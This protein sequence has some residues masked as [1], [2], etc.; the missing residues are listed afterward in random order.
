M[1]NDEKTGKD[2]TQ[3]TSAPGGKDYYTSIEE[4]MCVDSEGFKRL[5]GKLTKEWIVCL[6]KDAVSHLKEAK[7]TANILNAVDD[8]LIKLTSCKENPNFPSQLLNSI[9]EKL[10]TANVVQPGRLPPKTED[11]NNHQLRLKFIGVSE[12]K[13]KSKLERDLDDKN[14]VDSIIADLG[15]ADASTGCFGLG[16]PAT[17]GDTLYKSRPSLVT[18]KNIWERRKCLA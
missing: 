3:S 2:R 9:N 11:N 13:M 15:S 14:A 10:D 5:T 17:A 8:K 7:C 6:L 18:F 16:R 12:S 4:L 1:T